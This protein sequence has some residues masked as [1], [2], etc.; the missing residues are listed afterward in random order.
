MNRVEVKGVLGNIRLLGEIL[1]PLVW[2]GLVAAIALIA[3][4]LVYDKTVLAVLFVLTA[5][6]GGVWGATR[7]SQPRSNDAPLKHAERRVMI[8]A[9][10]LVAPLVS[11]YIAVEVGKWITHVS[12]KRFDAERAMFLADP[13]GFPALQKLAREQYGI[14][15]VLGDRKESWATTTVDLPIASPAMMSLGPGYC[16]LSMNRANVRHMLAPVGQISEG[17]WVLGAA[18]HEFAHCLD[19]SRDMHAFGE[20]ALG[21]HSL[22]PVDAKGVRD[23]EGYLDASGH[24]TTKLWREA[25]ADTFAVGYWKVTA[26]E[27]AGNL[28]ASLRRTR[29]SRSDDLTHATMCWIDY[30]NL[31]AAPASTASLFEWA[32]RL[33]TSAPCELPKPKKLTRIQQWARDWLSIAVES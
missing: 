12:M 1:F 29:A 9:L 13:E 14:D 17:Q 23:L 10:A 33:R 2:T 8:G 30:A 32:D 18:M 3:W 27:A 24:E 25:I 7:P 28:I 5:V 15:V 20:K 16:L 22:A 6:C 11:V 31:A 19:V 4:A 21:T 26:P